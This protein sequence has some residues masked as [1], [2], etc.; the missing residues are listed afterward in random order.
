MMIKKE[1]I[2][3]ICILAAIIVGTI[4]LIPGQQNTTTV[5]KNHSVEQLSPTLSDQLSNVAGRIS[6]NLALNPSAAMVGG[7]KKMETILVYKTLP[8]VVTNETTLD[9][10]KKFNVTG[11]LRGGQVIQSEDLRY[12]VQISKKSGTVRYQDARRPNAQT[13]AP[14]MLPTDDEAVKIAIKFL[15]DRDLYPEGAAFSK[16]YRENAIAVSEKPERVVFGQI[17]VWLNRTLNGMKVEGTQLVVYVGGNGDVIGY[18][19][20]WREY[21]PYKEYPLITPQDAFDKLKA[22]GIPVGM[23]NPE[24]IVSIDDVR[25]AYK[26][27]AG[28]YSEEYLEPVWVFKGYVVVD[29]KAADFVETDIPALTDEAVKSLSSS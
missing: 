26:T 20:N 6:H 15:K 4:F 28:A 16:T 13:D 1:L 19:A 11:T 7:T 23:N 17:G 22:K 21:E 2:M 18:Y 3:G 12:G 24:S 29:G 10:A 5:I 8:P 27:K 9:Y 25:L 14:E